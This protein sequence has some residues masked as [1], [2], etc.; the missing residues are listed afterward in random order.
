MLVWAGT[1]AKERELRVRGSGLDP[2]LR[3]LH[4]KYLDLEQARMEG[5]DEVQRP[6]SQRPLRG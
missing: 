4:L 5:M 6:P 3:S 1:R 2:G